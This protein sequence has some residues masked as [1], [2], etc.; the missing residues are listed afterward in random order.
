MR[1]LII[2]IS[3]LY[4]GSFLSGQTIQEDN[5]GQGELYLRIKNI[6]FFKND[7]YF[8][9]ISESDF[10]LGSSIPGYVDKSQW[11]E[12]YTLPGFFFQPELVYKPSSSLTL[13]GGIHLL[14]YYGSENF[15]LI[16]PVI[17]TSLKIS[18]NTV[19][20]LGALSGSDTHKMFD[21][22]FYSERLYTNYLE[23]GL[24]FTHK[25]DHFFTDT[26]ISWENYIIKTDGK[27]E[28]FTF[29]ESFTYTSPAIAEFMHVEI[30]MQVEFKHF[31]GQITDFPEHVETFFNSAAGA[32]IN[33]DIAGKKYGE[34]G[35]EYLYFINS[36]LP[37]RELYTI[38]NGN[39]SWLRFHY[40][41]KALYVGAA[42]W[43][44]H[45]FYAPNGNPIYASIIDFASDYVIPD[46]KVVTN[47]IYLNL[48]PQ[49]NLELRIGLETYYNTCIKKMDY[50]YT[51]HLNFDKL[52]RLAEIKN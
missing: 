1:F 51:F 27:R 31:G 34:A 46:R 18:K 49:S 24:Q 4:C 45:N 12:G 21:P 10:E 39:G 5:T 28:I 30:P 33:F 20:T 48:L 7:E 17:S 32:R 6:N 37:Q 38:T 16:R 19:F 43:D 47:S 41:Y 23:N 9:N 13:R 44:A 52:F 35:I 26:W 42:I 8:N 14:W 22:H 50:A 40:T 25:D 36:V 2:F 29:G 11:I 15:T 3:L